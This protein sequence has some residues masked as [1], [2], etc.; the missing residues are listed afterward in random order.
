MLK[1]R[2]IVKL[3]MIVRSKIMN[4]IN[5]EIQ[6]NWNYAWQRTGSKKPVMNLLLKAIIEHDIEQADYLYSQ[7][8]VL[9]RCDETTLKRILF[10]VMDDYSVIKWIIDHG[11][12]KKKEVFQ[13]TIGEKCISTSGYLWG[14]PARAYYLGAYD[15]LDLLCANGFSNFNWYE[16]E[17]GDVDNIENA[18]KYIIHSGDE[19]G[20]KI[21]LE[22]G[23]V[24]WP[25]SGTN[26]YDYQIYVLD[27]PQ[28][29]R[30]TNGLDKY[31]FKDSIPKPK[32]EDVP[33]FLG[34]KEAKHRNERRMEDYNDRI[35]A[36]SEFINWYGVEQFNNYLK[37]LSEFDK[38]CSRTIR[39]MAN[40]L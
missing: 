33:L 39:Y 4:D 12:S 23:Y 13:Y 37:E 26:K 16:K 40:E 28:V 20:L 3:D 18:D 35:R 25:I 6:Y 30:K 29:R 19:K 31:R 22:N 15:V 38:M 1:S 8:A 11:T 10:E 9:D 2:P 17:W 7:G 5:E 21:L 24:D 34:R 14:L 36:H 32:L 27:R